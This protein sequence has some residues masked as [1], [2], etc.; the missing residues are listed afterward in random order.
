MELKHRHDSQSQPENRTRVEE[1]PEHLGVQGV[2]IPARV[3]GL[4]HPDGLAEIVGLVPPPQPH[5]QPARYVFHVPEVGGEKKH[6]D[7]EVEDVIG[8]EKDAEEVYQERQYSEEE[9]EEQRDG[10]RRLGEPLVQGSTASLFGL[11]GVYAS[12]LGLDLVRLLRNLVESVWIR[13][14]ARN[15]ELLV[16][17]DTHVVHDGD[18]REQI[19]GELA[20]EQRSD[21]RTFAS[22]NCERDMLNLNMLNMIKK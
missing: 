5:H 21:R 18:G 22:S 19:E 1:E 16:C 9:E 15:V 3:G 6:G 14:E 2:D 7:D 8:G 4:E 11:G 10:M 17:V 20:L 12:E 13:P